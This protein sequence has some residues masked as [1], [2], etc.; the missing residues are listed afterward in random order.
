M[1]ASPATEYRGMFYQ[2]PTDAEAVQT[3][4]SGLK[5]RRP[6]FVIIMPDHTSTPGS[7]HSNY[8]PPGVYAVF[9]D[10]TNGYWLGK[11]FQTPPLFPWLSR[12]SL[13]Y[14]TVNPPI[15]IFIRDGKHH[16]IRKSEL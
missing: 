5:K 13:D 4:F 10:G 1:T 3:I 15:R 16:S 11:F 2:P 9:Q 12:P 7:E 6:K 8:C 14:P